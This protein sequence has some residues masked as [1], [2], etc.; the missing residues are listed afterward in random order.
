MQM[1]SYVPTRG[2]ALT[3][4]PLLEGYLQRGDCWRAGAH[5]RQDL[6]GEPP[7]R[8]T[9]SLLNKTKGRACDVSQPSAKT[10]PTSPY[11]LVSLVGDRGRMFHVTIQEH[12][13]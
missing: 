4:M 11:S 2:S 7:I 10:A 6:A 3:N 8:R 5:C 9:P 13:M 12:L 1:H